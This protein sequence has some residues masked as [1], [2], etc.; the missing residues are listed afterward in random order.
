[1]DLAAGRVLFQNSPLS[2]RIVE[3]RAP[4]A[5]V[6][7]PVV[8]PSAIRAAEGNRRPVR[9]VLPSPYENWRDR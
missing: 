2:E 1:M 8:L 4:V 6:I 5:A 9:V 3:I 7:V